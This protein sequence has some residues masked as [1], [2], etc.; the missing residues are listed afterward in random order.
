LRITAFTFLPRGNCTGGRE[1]SPKSVLIV[2]VCPRRT[3]NWTLVTRCPAKENVAVCR[4]RTVASWDSDYA[5]SVIQDGTY[6]LAVPY[7]R[8]DWV[9]EV[10]EPGQPITQVMGVSVVLNED[11]HLDI[12]AVHGGSVGGHVDGIAPEW[13]NQV[14]V[15]AFTRIGLRYETPVG[16]DGHYAFGQLPP[17][18]YGL[19]A[20]HDALH[21]SERPQE[22][23]PDNDPAYGS[24]SDPWRRAKIVRIEADR[25]S[26][27]ELL[28][29]PKE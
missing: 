24:P 18:E 14:W 12:A 11:K 28:E 2:S 8:D 26:A 16:S 15:V 20:S 25:K 22:P 29:L 7:Q 23:I 6:S 4:G 10:E 17:G 5:N 1:V 3:L 21:D 13:T 19:K 9:V 27:D